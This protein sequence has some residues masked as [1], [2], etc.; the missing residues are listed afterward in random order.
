MLSKKHVIVRST[1]FPAWS[2]RHYPALLAAQQG[3]QKSMGKRPAP[4]K[5]D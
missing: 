1:L 2:Q 4:L 5:N 3:F